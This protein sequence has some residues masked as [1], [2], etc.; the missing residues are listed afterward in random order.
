MTSKEETTI[1]NTSPG[2]E[3]PNDGQS[4][5]HGGRGQCLDEML[6]KMKDDPDWVLIKDSWDPIALFK[7]IERINLSLSTATVPCASALHE[8]ITDLGNDSGYD[9][10]SDYFQSPFYPIPASP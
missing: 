3:Q 1:S 10:Y 4:R 9:Y 5:G 8:F 2:A 7:L 6:E